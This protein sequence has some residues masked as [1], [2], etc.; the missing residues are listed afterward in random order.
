MPKFSKATTEP[1]TQGP[2]TEWRSQLDGYTSS[3]VSV[4]HDADLTPL[5]QGLP[6]DQCPSPHWGFV[7]KGEM[8]WR[9]DDHEEIIRAGEAFYAPPGHTSGAHGGSEFVVFSP[10]EIMA[11]VEAHMMRRA[12]ELYAPTEG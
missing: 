9:Y 6:G 11:D 10:T 2:G 5:L 1:M 7:F 8:W 3:L 12:Q 4:D